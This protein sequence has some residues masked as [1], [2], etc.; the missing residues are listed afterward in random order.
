M[1][2]LDDPTVDDGSWATVKDNKKD[3]RKNVN[4]KDSES[5][6]ATHNQESRDSK[7]NAPHGNKQGNK[8]AKSDVGS[9]RR[10]S[11]EETKNVNSDPVK[12]INLGLI[13]ATPAR[14]F[15][16]YR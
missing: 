12:V 15:F 6:A 7:N 2:P 3:K 11:K 16:Y 4:R 13:R 10:P 1:K 5:R 8:N 9:K 14:L